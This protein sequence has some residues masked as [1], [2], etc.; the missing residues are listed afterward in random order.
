MLTSL[1]YKKRNCM[2][3]KGIFIHSALAILCKLNTFFSADGSFLPVA[4][5][6]AKYWM[7]FLVFT[8]F[9]APDS[10]LRIKTSHSN[11]HNK[12][13]RKKILVKGGLLYYI[14]ISITYVIRT[15]WFSLSVRKKNKNVSL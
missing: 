15:D 12:Q 13:H 7:T 2:L 10:P 1:I 8:V 4:A 3:C 14:M 6:L 11:S 5:M 9:P